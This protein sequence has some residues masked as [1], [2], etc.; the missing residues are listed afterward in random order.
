MV[1]RSSLASLE[2]AGAPVPE[3]PAEPGAADDVFAPGALSPSQ[4]MTSPTA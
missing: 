1:A 2:L 4:V 3:S